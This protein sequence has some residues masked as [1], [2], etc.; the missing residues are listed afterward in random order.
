MNLAGSLQKLTYG[1]TRKN[2]LPLLVELSFACARAAYCFFFID[3]SPFPRSLDGEEEEE[4]R[5]IRKNEFGEG[6]RL[7]KVSQNLKMTRSK[8]VRI[9]L[10][11]FVPYSYIYPLSLHHG[12]FF[13]C[14]P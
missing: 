11:I 9:L 10:S 4:V 2:C 12:S 14:L 3:F 13:S 5:L 6:K 1:C 8:K 7:G